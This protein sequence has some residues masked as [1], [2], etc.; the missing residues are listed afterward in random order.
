MRTTGQLST[1]VETASR[2]TYATFG[3]G[4]FTNGQW[5]MLGVVVPLYAAFIGLSAVDLGLIVGARSILPTVLSIHG[6]ILMDRLGTRRVT[7]WLAV[8]MATLPLLYPVSGW[9][10]ALFILQMAVGFAV[11]SRWQEH[12]P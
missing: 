2:A 10:V 3:A 6:G 11:T 4:L 8:V 7:I 5:D 9:F 1:T 12:K